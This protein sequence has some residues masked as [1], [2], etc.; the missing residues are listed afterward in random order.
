MSQQ[1]SAGIKPSPQEKQE[2]IHAVPYMFYSITIRLCNQE[3]FSETS[4]S[5]FVLLGNITS[6]SAFHSYYRFVLIFCLLII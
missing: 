5:C 4:V 2:Q 1:V 3:L 6:D